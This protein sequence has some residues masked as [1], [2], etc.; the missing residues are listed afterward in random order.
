MKTKTR[1]SWVVLAVVLSPW[2]ALAKPGA[3]EGSDPERDRDRMERAGQ[4]ME[5]A[6][7]R[8]R[9]RQVLTLSDVLELDNAQALKVEETLRQFDEKRRPLR[10][11]VR[12]AAR[13]LHQAA[14]GDSAAQAQVDTAALRAFEARER[15]A[16]LD[17]EMYQA[18]AKGLAPEK[19]AKLALALARGGGKHFRGWKDDSSKGMRGD[20]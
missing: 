2:L 8:M 12:E 1:K 7:Q 11:Q 3:R 4:R 13:T 10:E 14:R 9:L 17:K 16:A 20:D 19:R 15:I 18:L 6:E 5:R